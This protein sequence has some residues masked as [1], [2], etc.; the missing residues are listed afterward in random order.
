[1]VLLISRKQVM[2]TKKTGVDEEK[3]WENPVDPE[4]PVDKR[5]A[6]KIV[7]QQKEAKRRKENLTETDHID[8][9]KIKK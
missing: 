1:M 9:I 8:K 6:E 5:D 4:K 3:N 7:R 2:T